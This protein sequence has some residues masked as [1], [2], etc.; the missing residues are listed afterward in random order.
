MLQYPYGQPQMNPY[1]QPQINPYGQPP[2]MNPYG[3]QPQMNPYGQPILQQP[4]M[5]AYGQM[6]QLQRPIP[7]QFNQFGQPIP[8]QF[9]GMMP[10]NTYGTQNTYSMNSLKGI[11][12]NISNLMISLNIMDDEGKI[13]LDIPQFLPSMVSNTFTG[14]TIFLIPTIPLTMDMLLKAGLYEKKDLTPSDFVDTFSNIAMVNKLLVYI[15]NKYSID[16]T[17]IEE[18][19]KKGYIRENIDLLLSIYFN[20]NN[21]IKLYNQTYPIHSFRWDEK[22]EMSSDKNKQL[23]IF[24]INVKLFVMDYNKEGTDE[25]RKDF[26]CRI[27]R[28]NIEQDLN[29]LGL[30]TKEEFDLTSGNKINICRKFNTWLES[31]SGGKSRKQ[32]KHLKKIKKNK[33]Y[34]SKSVKR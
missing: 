12:H 15:K 18:A 30:R 6:P 29:N 31:L 11:D 25:E 1:G 20:K 13:N 32:R 23:P 28:N 34:T 21:K 8:T 10:Y 2:Q 5:N 4:Q 22:I 26:T 19:Y 16:K 14:N 27:K 33:R 9:P 17:T 24:K 3:Q 7:S